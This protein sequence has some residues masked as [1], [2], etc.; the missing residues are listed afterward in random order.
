MITDG[1]V[2]YLKSNEALS[3]IMTAIVPVG[4]V[5][6]IKSPCVVYHI[7]T[8]VGQFTTSGA[9]PWQIARF[10]FDA[11]SATSYT[12]ARAVAVALRNA[13][14][15][16][17]NVTLADTDETYVYGVFPDPPVDMPYEAQG[18][19]NVEYRVMVQCEVH[20]LES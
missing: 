6:G 12:E 9:T 16:L 8:A 1:I 14:K 2:G 5:K 19:Q 7:G 18:I 17:I 13:L 3:A 20:F 15:T 11:Y 10:Q 4:M